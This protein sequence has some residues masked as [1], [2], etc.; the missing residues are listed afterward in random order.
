MRTRKTKRDKETLE[1]VP[2]KLRQTDAFADKQPSTVIRCPECWKLFDST[3]T[4]T[5]PHC[6][7]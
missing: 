2:T 3:A 7:R 1:L 5:C 4:Q 6:G